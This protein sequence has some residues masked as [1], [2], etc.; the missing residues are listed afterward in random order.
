MGT[1]I[2]NINNLIIPCIHDTRFLSVKKIII[3][4]NKNKKQNQ[5][6]KPKQ[7]KEKKN[8]L[9]KIPRELLFHS[10]SGVTGFLPPSLQLLLWII[11]LPLSKL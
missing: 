7:N 2:R 11:S 1:F 6:Q 9:C 5:K 10:F 8:S 4:K 3:K